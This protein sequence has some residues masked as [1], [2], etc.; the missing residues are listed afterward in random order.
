VSAASTGRRAAGITEPP[1][2]PLP[3][4]SQPLQGVTLFFTIQTDLRRPPSIEIWEVNR[5]VFE[6]K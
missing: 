3:Q 5:Q 6:K 2:P 1:T 4:S